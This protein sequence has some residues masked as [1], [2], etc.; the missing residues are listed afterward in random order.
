MPAA[1]RYFVDVAFYD[2]YG[3]IARNE[4]VFSER[5]EGARFVDLIRD[6]KKRDGLT[7][8]ATVRARE[9]VAVVGVERF[10]VKVKDLAVR[11]GKHPGSVSR[12][13]AEAA[14]RAGVR[15]V[16]PAVGNGRCEG[17][18]RDLAVIMRS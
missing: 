16:L 10:G 15:G 12:W 7:V 3:R 9:I 8:P 5:G 1:P 14:G 18:A 6:V 13:V 4:M 11:L 17:C 2:A